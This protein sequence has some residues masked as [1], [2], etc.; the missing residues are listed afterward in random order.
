[1]ISASKLIKR[2]VK[3]C[4]LP[5]LTAPGLDKSGICSLIKRTLQISKI[6]YYNLYYASRLEFY[7]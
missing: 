3:F 5:D 7:L 4:P 2:L 6:L 1:M